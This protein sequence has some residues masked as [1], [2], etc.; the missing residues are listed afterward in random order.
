[1]KLEFQIETEEDI[2]LLTRDKQIQYIP[3]ICLY[4]AIVGLCF[5]CVYIYI[6]RYEWML[7][8]ALHFLRES[9]HV[10]SGALAYKNE[11]WKSISYRYIGDG[12]CT[13][14]TCQTSEGTGHGNF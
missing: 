1:M 10:K 14:K 13:P 8:L 9:T 12:F 6:Y 3:K 7:I 2:E 11:M 5:A 4:M